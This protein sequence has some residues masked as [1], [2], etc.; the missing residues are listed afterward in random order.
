MAVKQAQK[1]RISQFLSEVD[2]AFA[3][4][5]VCCIQDFAAPTSVAASSQLNWISTTGHL[6][7]PAEELKTLQ[8]HAEG[9]FAA[10]RCRHGH[11]SLHQARQGGMGSAPAAAWRLCS[12]EVAQAMMGYLS[13]ITVEQG[14]HEDF[15][16]ADLCMIPKPGKKRTSQLT[17]DRW[18]FSV[19]TPTLNLPIYRAEAS[20]MHLIGSSVICARLVNLLAVTSF[21]REFSCPPRSSQS[22]RRRWWPRIGP[23][24]QMRLRIMSKSPNAWTLALVGIRDHHK[25]HN[26]SNW[27]YRHGSNLHMCDVETG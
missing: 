11:P 21:I 6:L 15:L 4:G 1:D 22:C 5:S 13:S 9:I 2:Q 24:V 7:S 3:E 16:N 14:L 26:V 19:Q 18:A 12:Q 8:Q 20:P 10:Q 23:S 17:S 27:G 25:C